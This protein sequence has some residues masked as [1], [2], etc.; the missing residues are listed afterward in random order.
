MYSFSWDHVVVFHAVKHV[1]TRGIVH[2]RT[3][4]LPPS[5]RSRFVYFSD[6]LRRVTTSSQLGPPNKPRPGVTALQSS[7]HCDPQGG[8]NAIRHHK[9]ISASCLQLCLKLRETPF[10]PSEISKRSTGAKRYQP[11]LP[12]PHRK[13]GKSHFRTVTVSSCTC[14]PLSTK[15]VAPTRKIEECS[16]EALYAIWALKLDF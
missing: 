2:R 14:S 10:R 12:T 3:C 1:I 4:A 16:A 11:S 15:V 7:S 8:M 9:I 6:P 5:E 13:L